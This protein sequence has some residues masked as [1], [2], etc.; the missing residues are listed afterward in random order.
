MAQ[1]SAAPDKASSR[2]VSLDVFRGITIAAMVLVNN[3]GSWGH[4]YAPLGH[5]P[6]DGWTPTDFIFPFFLFIVGVAMT[7]S[8]DKRLARGD[9]HS[10][11]FEGVVHRTL[12]LFALGMLMA[13]FPN[14]RL[15]AP[16]LLLIVGLYTCASPDKEDPALEAKW[17]RRRPIGYG[18]I[19]VG[20]LWFLLDL[21]HFNGPV[22]ASSFAQIFPLTNDNGG[23]IVRV[24]GVLQRIA[25][26][27]FFA[28]I[29][30]MKFGLLGRIA[31]TL[32]L[33]NLYW[34]IMK[35]IQPPAGFSILTEGKNF[36]QDAPAG[37]PFPGLLNDWIDR[38]LLGEHLYRYRPDPEGLLSTLP[39]ISTTLSG[40]LAGTW[41][42]THHDKATK[43]VGMFIAGSV[44]F[45]IGL[46]M[47]IWFPINKKIWTS[48]YVVFVTGWALIGL[49]LCYW[50]NDV[51][52]WR[53]WSAPFMV[54]GTN[55]ILI[56]FCSGIL[57]RLMSMIKIGG[58]NAVDS[59][60]WI[61]RNICIE[62]FGK[63]GE[64]GVRMSDKNASL[65]FAIGF[66]LFWLLVTIP[67]YRMRIFLKV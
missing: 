6:W 55:A 9:S 14:M 50:A 64:D 21:G 20:A 3:P 13:A 54:F 42:H 60:T 15:S 7:F 37:A 29:I 1:A 67:L 46:C 35:Y 52:G 56:F 61:Y 43:A 30:M 4:I 38:A 57:A 16:W 11:L 63:L 26:C 32:G 18:L 39:A 53:R 19:G 8:F 25:L 22:R 44:L 45:I 49:A 59:K 27:Y 23:G 41:L 66:V 33:I 48:S 51:K 24:P 5:A 58:E 10:K 36:V 2:L 47:D 31:W 12:I 62:F 40:I 28:S 17:R 65:S 34:L